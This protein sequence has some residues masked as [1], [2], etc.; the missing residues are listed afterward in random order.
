MIT[1]L[2]NKNELDK[3]KK[4]VNQMK[5]KSMIIMYS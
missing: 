5:N 2:K 1:P 4:E 3:K